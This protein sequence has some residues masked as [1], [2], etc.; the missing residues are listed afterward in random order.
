M[1]CNG[2][3]FIYCLDF[4]KI[5]DL[6]YRDSVWFIVKKYGMF[7]KLLRWLKLYIMYDDFECFVIEDNEVIVFCLVKIGVR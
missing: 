5:F 2:I 4:E 1:E 3:M 7:K 6:E